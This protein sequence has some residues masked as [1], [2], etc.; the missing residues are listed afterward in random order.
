PVVA[1]GIADGK[2]AV[3]YVRE[4]ADRW[5]LKT[6]RIGI[7][8]FSAGGTVTSGVCFQ[9][10]PASR[11]DFA[12][13][14]YPYVG[15]YDH[16]TV[17]ADAPPIFIAGAGDDNFGFHLHCTALYE[18]WV[19]AGKSASLVLYR[20]GGHGFGMRKQGLPS[21]GWIDAFYAWLTHL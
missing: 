15:S 7:M 14:I 8:G 21:D 19:R 20:T 16:R 9:F 3:A 13:P 12:A 2:A 5:N 17:P 10:D 4:H 1:L 11:P 18:Q 6:D